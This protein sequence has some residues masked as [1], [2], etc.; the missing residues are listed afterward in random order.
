[1]IAETFESRLWAALAES[2]EDEIGD[3]T[4][5]TMKVASEIGKKPTPEATK[6]IEDEYMQKDAKG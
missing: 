5:K 1:M 3:D 4:K 6:E 2:D